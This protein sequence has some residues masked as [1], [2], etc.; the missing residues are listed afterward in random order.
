MLFWLVAAF[1]LV[2]PWWQIF[3]GM[4]DGFMPFLLCTL[5]AFLFGIVGFAL[6]FCY[7]HTRTGESGQIARILL[8]SFVSLAGIGGSAMA[9]R[10]IWVYF[11]PHT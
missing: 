1:W 8:W 4:A 9:V 6:Y 3:A 11:L 10:I 7:R 5:I 2:L